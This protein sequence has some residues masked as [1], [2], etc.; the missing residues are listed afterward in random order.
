M[1][2]PAAL[3]RGE[4]Q[5]LEGLGLSVS[6]RGFSDYTLLI[7]KRDPGQP[8]IWAA[9][10]ALIIGLAITFYLPRRRVWARFRADGGLDLVGRSDR[11][12]DFDREFGSLV[13]ELIAARGG[14]RGGP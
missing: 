8:I 4:T 7:A 3:V 14:T 2:F 10:A 11:Y 5:S 1:G 6:L 12:V 13:D 9:F